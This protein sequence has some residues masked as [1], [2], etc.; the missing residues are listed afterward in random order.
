MPVLAFAR[1]LALGFARLGLTAPRLV[2]FAM[3]V[4]LPK[5]VP[6]PVDVN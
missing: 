4:P 6:M 2:F 1:A 5:W 3:K